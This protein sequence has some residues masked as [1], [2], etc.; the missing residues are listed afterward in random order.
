MAFSDEIQDL[1]F[2][3]YH[4]NLNKPNPKIVDNI[5]HNP[6]FADRFGLNN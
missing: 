6:H 1:G 3:F 2:Y 4:K 5:M